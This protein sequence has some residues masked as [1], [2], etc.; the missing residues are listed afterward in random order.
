[1]KKISIALAIFTIITLMSSIVF[2]ATT[3]KFEVVDR[4]GCT[5]KLNDYCTFEKKLVS[6]DIN[7]RQVTIQLSVTNDAPPVQPTGEVML[8]LDDSNSM[9]DDTSTGEKRGTLVYGAAKALVTKMLNNNDNLK[10]GIVKFSTESP[11]SEGTINDAALVSELT[12]NVTSLTN[13]IDNIEKAGLRTDL[14]AGLTLAEQKFSSENT[15][16]YMI[17]L[18]DGVPNVAIGSNDYYGPVVINQTKAK[19]QN[20]SSKCNIITML[21]GI[22]NPEQQAGIHDYTFQY[23]IENIFGTP[24]NPTTGKFYYIEDPDIQKTI[25]EDIYADLLPKPVTITDINISDYFPQNIVDNFNFAYVSEPT[26]GTISSKIDE[27]N[28]I[29]WTLDELSSGE[30]ATVQ[31]TLTLKDNYDKSIENIILDTNEKVDITY[32]NS[33]G[34]ESSK[35]SKETPKVRIVSDTAP[36]II[37][38]AGSTATMIGVGILAVIAV[39]SG[40]RIAKINK[41]T[42]KQ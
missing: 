30:T 21:T 10:I 38:A 36:T 34:T 42:S 32:I 26:K 25:T 31:Y 41:D 6:E 33:D 22:N 2:A 8:V 29:V 20:L 27:N 17:I 23:V 13:A 37:P 28:K 1:M 9:N 11:T 7:K 24:T 15:N 19:L 14:E 40:I 18:T 3:S 35:T 4:T 16:K 39:A 12:N 5:I